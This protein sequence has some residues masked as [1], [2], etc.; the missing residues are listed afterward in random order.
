MRWLPPA[1]REDYYQRAAMARTMSGPRRVQ[2][3]PKLSPL[4]RSSR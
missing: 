4:C 2:N 3:S 1:E